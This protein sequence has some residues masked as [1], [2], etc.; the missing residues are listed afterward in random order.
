[1]KRLVF[2]LFVIGFMLAVMV[3]AQNKKEIKPLGLWKMVEAFS[4]G[5]KVSQEFTNRTMFF[6]SDNK[7]ASMMK[8]GNQELIFNQGI[9][10]MYNDTIIAIFTDKN[11]LFID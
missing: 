6:S 8:I 10:Q 7:F 1:M 9:Y 3:S 5:E 4:G 2:S 11:P